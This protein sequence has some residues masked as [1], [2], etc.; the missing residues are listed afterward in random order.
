MTELQKPLECMTEF[1][2]MTQSQL[3]LVTELPK[4]TV[5]SKESPE[6]D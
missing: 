4:A 6:A 2:R 1:W 3:G 5:A